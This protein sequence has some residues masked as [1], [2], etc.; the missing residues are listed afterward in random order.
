MAP[1]ASATEAGHPEGVEV[2]LDT[3]H[4]DGTLRA[5][6]GSRKLKF[7]A[8]RS[9]QARWYSPISHRHLPPS[10]VAVYSHLFDVLQ[11]ISIP[12]LYCPGW[13]LNLLGPKRKP[14][15]QGHSLKLDSRAVVLGP[16]CEQ[17]AVR[18]GSLLRSAVSDFGWKTPGESGAPGSSVAERHCNR[19]ASAR[20]DRVRL[21]W[22]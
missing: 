16:F 1:P 6:P 21:R 7:S 19:S 9:C 11:H 13:P 3:N 4:L 17:F 2:S 10:A 14:P 12:P 20:S 15:H 18:V 8:G 5:I 22:S